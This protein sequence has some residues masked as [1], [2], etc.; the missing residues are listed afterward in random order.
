M[1]RTLRVTAPALAAVLAATLL[2]APPASAASYP[3]WDD[4][5]AA[6]SDES[7]T[8]ERISELTTLLD[9]LRRE[10]TTLEA[11]AR[12]R[13]EEL[14]R[15]QDAAD[16]ATETLRKLTADVARAE[17]AA[18]ES[19]SQVA[20]WAAS[21]TRTGGTDLTTTIVASGSG[22][23]DLLSRLGTATQ[24][25]RTA[26]RMLEEAAVAGNAARALED[27]AQV[28]TTERDRLAGLAASARDE[29][30]E[31]VE[32]AR[33]AVTEQEARSID[34]EAQLAVLEQA[35]V[36]AEEGFAEAEAIRIRA[37]ADAARRAAAARAAAAAAS[38]TE[39]APTS[40]VVS[41]A[42]WTMPI[43]SY[44]SYQAYGMRVHPVLGFVKRHAGADFG[45]SC[46]TGIY[47]AAAGTVTYA[48]A[49]GGYGNL[50]TITSAGGVSTNYAHMYAG[51]VQVS[52][53]QTVTAGQRIAEVGSAG[54]STGCH[55]HFELRQGGAATDPVAYL[56]NRGV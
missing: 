49:Y 1:T 53:G 47:A 34:L 41:A 32:S 31:A 38:S 54:L 21:L 48:G 35:T 18:A 23:D 16:E 42:G 14:Q 25:S 27:Q 4:V 22:A 40:S 2:T 28:A 37:E 7:A 13:G 30:V 19:Q 52:V 3:T 20:R 12:Q 6:R 9:D 26:N 56:T 44:S 10:A 43:T 8:A 15:T 36:S 11:L 46:G 50:I 39:A 17:T 55:L 5:L 45:A 51:G 29:A 24:V 33:A